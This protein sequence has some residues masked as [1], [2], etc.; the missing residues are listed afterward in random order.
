MALELLASG[1]VDVKPLITHHYKLTQIKEAFERARS[2][3][4]GAVK[5]IVDCT[6]K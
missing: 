4:D 3:A 5:V 1:K 2:G 6:E